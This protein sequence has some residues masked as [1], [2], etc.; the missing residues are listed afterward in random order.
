MSLFEKIVHRIQLPD[1]IYRFSIQKQLKQRLAFESQRYSECQFSE[2]IRFLKN[3]P[4]AIEMDKA[5]TQHYQVPT[6]FYDVILGSFKKY[7]CCYWDDSTETLDEAEIKMLELSSQ[8]A[9][10]Q[11]GQSILDL[12]CGWGS[13]SLFIASK[14]PSTKITSVSNSKTQKDYIDSQAQKMGLK[15]VNVIT[16][17][18]ADLDLDATFDRI[19]SIEMLEH[20]RNYE[21]LFKKVSNWLKSDGLFFAHIFGHHCY[22]YLFDDQDENSWMAR[23]FF[24]GGQMPSHYLFSRFDSHLLVKQDWVINGEHYKKTCLAWLKQMD[25][26]Q[27]EIFSIFQSFYGTD[28]VK[29]WIYWRI[30]F[31][32]C[33]ELFGFRCGEEWQVYH[34]LFHK[35][36]KFDK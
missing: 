4:I 27:K 9:N 33:I 31:L 15:N 17:N 35:K 2:Y 12:G 11:E 21:L 25:E 28:A 26:N 5:N 1:I 14:Y 29:Y 6:A 20:I 18:V 24:S 16:K 8:R 34:Y 7:S 13:F 19:I 30:F 3:S 32:S 23:Y 36:S 10:I 22:P